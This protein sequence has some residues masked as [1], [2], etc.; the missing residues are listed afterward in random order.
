MM[1]TFHEFITRTGAPSMLTR[2]HFILE[3]A[4]DNV[5]KINQ[6][7]FEKYAKYWAIHYQFF[8]VMRYV[9]DDTLYIKF[10]YSERRKNEL[11]ELT[12]LVNAFYQNFIGLTNYN[13]INCLTIPFSQQIP[14]A[15]LVA[16][17]SM[18]ELEKTHLGTLD[19]SSW[20]GCDR[21][22]NGSVIAHGK[23][24]LGLFFKWNQLLAEGY[25]SQE[26]DED[27]MAERLTEEEAIQKIKELKM[28][29]EVAIRKA[30]ELKNTARYNQSGG[31]NKLLPVNQSNSYPAFLKIIDDALRSENLNIM[32]DKKPELEDSNDHS[33]QLTFFKK[34]S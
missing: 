22:G 1:E 26:Y 27:Y 5:R 23:W 25:F 17:S 31:L 2:K 19:E 16:C 18:A 12:D 21:F 28:A 6:T 4:T 9:K 13:N 30:N 8:P 10:Y 33:I 20:I 15:Q 34:R 32:E 7:V 14:K 29:K 24:P 3:P 11:R